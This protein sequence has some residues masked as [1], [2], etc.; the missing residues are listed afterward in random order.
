MMFKPFPELRTERLFLRKLKTSDGDVIFFLQSD[1]AVTK[2][3]ERPDER[4]IK[5]L[6]GAVKFIDKLKWVEL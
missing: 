6:S 3:I 1:A 5:N 4:K 2:F